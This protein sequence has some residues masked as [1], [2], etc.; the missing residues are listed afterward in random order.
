MITYDQAGVTYDDPSVLYDGGTLTVTYDPTLARVRIAGVDLGA[1]DHAVIDRS[2][3]GVAW[4]TVRGGAAAE[5]TG[6]TVRLDD[7][8]F[9]DGTPATYRLRLYDAA[10]VLLGTLT[11]TVTPALGTVWLKNVGRPYL[12]RAVVVT[13]FGDVTAPARGGV[14]E[15]LGRRLPVAVTDVRGSRRYDLEVR[16]S[17]LEIADAIE[18]A[19]SFGDPMFVHVPADC[20]VPR[21]MYAFVGDVTQ[22]RRGKHDTTVRYFTLPLTEVDAPEASVVGSTVTC[23][24]ILAAFATCADVLAAFPT[25]LDMLDYVSDPVDEVVG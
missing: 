23:A 2:T 6:G 9:T 10:D 4:T 17:D 5:V 18:L 8:E 7:Y 1:A 24:G 13:G 12:N 21:S 22:A 20:V 25:V 3:N 19:L 11:G 14:F 16:A 15:V